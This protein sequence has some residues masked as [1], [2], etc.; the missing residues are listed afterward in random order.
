M[1]M[2]ERNLAGLTR[3]P[4]CIATIEYSATG[5]G[6]THCLLAQR[7][8]SLEAFKKW[9]A[10][11]VGEFLPIGATWFVNQLPPADDGILRLLAS[12]SVRERWTRI[13]NGETESGTY[14][15]R[16]QQHTNFG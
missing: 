13:L 11:Q 8:Q 2:K 16:A 4:F 12:A 1:E 10:E 14:T 5:E 6:V 9:V 7:A 15:F 3:Y